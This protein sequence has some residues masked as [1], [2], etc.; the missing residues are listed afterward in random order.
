MRKAL[1]GI[2][3]VFLS[4][5]VVAQTI[6]E[7]EYF[8][9]TD[10]G[11]G[12]G[13][14]VAITP[15][16]TI[17]EMFNVPTGALSI[18]FHDLFV[19]VK[20]D[21]GIITITPIGGT[22]ETEENVTSPSGTG[23]IQAAFPN[24]LE[25]K[26][27][28][29]NF[30]ATETVTG[31][32]SGATATIDSF[33]ANWS[34]PE[35][36]LIYID[37]T[38]AGIVQVDALE[39]FI[40][41]DPG[42]GMGTP[43]PAFSATA[44][45]NE[46]AN[47]PTGAL[48]LGFHT[49][50]V[51][52]RAVGGTWGLPE[53]RLVFVDPTAGGGVIL[54]DELEYFIDS[55]PGYG[56][57]TSF[58]AF[59]A[60]NVVNQM[61]NI[62]T[63]ALSV[64]FHTIFV[65][66]KSVEGTWGIPE[67]RI[68]YVD[69]SGGMVNVEEIEYFFDT[70]PGYGMGTQFTAFT[71]ANI[72]N[73]VENIAT[74]SLSFGFH[75]L[76]IR[77][78]SV[79]GTWGLP[80]SRI[81]YVD[82]SGTV[83]SD[84]AAL[85]YFLDTDPGYGMATSI[86]IGTPGFNVMEMFKIL[87]NDLPQG[88]HV[89][90]IRAQNNDGT[91]GMLETRTIT[92]EPT[93][94]LDFDGTD[95]YVVLPTSI[96]LNSSPA[97]TVEAWIILED[98][99]GE[100]VIYSE[101][102]SAGTMYVFK[103]NSGFVQMLVDN[104]TMFSAATSASQLE[105][106]RWY[107]VV[108]TY[109][110]GVGTKVYVQGIL[111]GQDA[112]QGRRADGI[113]T[114]TIGRQLPGPLYFDGAI[115]EI[116]LWDKEKTL[117]EIRNDM[118]IDLTG[119][120]ANLRGYYNFDQGFAGMNNSGLTT[121]IDATTNAFDGT[122]NNF[123]L[124]TD[125]S[126]WVKSQVPRPL[127]FNATAITTTGFEANW[128]PMLGATDVRIDVDDN[129]DF[130]SLILS[131]VSIATGGNDMI[132]VAL[133]PGTQYYYRIRGD[134]AGTITNN[135]EIISFMVKPGNS[136]H[137][138]G[139]DD[140]VN[141]GN[142]ASLYN[143]QNLTLEAW[144]KP[145]FTNV[146]DQ[147]TVIST[148]AASGVGGGY[149]MTLG[150]TGLV[151]IFYRDA[152]I[153]DRI[154]VSNTALQPGEWVHIAGVIENAGANSNLRLYINGNLDASSSAVPGVPDY[155]NV[156]PL[157][158]G[159]NGD[160]AAESNPGDREFGGEMDAV[161]IWNTARSQ[162]D[163]QDNL[164]SS[165]EG[166]EPGL[167][168]NYR[169]DQGN[170]NASN[171]G[172]D[173]LPD[174]AG[175]NDGTL[176]NFDLGAGDLNLSN[177]VVSGAQTPLANLV[178]TI[179]VAN[180]TGV[181][182]ADNIVFNFDSNLVQ[183]GIDKGTVGDVTDDAIKV[184]GSLSGLI[185]GTYSG[186]GTSTITFDP[187]QDLLPGE[188][189][190]VTVTAGNG[191]ASKHSFSFATSSVG[192]P[193]TPNFFRDDVS[194]PVTASTLDDPRSPVV[195]DL[196][197][198][199]DLDIVANSSGSGAQL[200]WYE[201]DGN[202][203][204]VENTLKGGVSFGVAASTGDVNSDGLVDVMYS[205]EVSNLFSW[206]ENQGGGSFIERPI[207]AAASSNARLILSA[208]IDADG[209]TDLLTGSRVSP[210][211]FWR[212]ND[213]S[214]SFAD[215]NITTSWADIVGMEI[216]DLDD[217][218]DLDIA[219]AFFAQNQVAWY[220]NDGVQNFTEISIAMPTA[221]N[222]IT[223]GDVNGDTHLDLV[224]LTNLGEVIWY[225]NGGDQ[226]F[227]PFVVHDFNPS[228]A[229]SSF[230]AD[231]DG[232]GDTDIV[233]GSDSELVWLDNDGSQNFTL[234]G[235]AMNG[236]YQTTPVA[237]MDADGDLDI[238][239]ATSGASDGVFVHL[240]AAP[241]PLAPSDL[242]PIE[243]NDSQIDLVW[244]DNSTNETGFIIERS[245]NDNLSFMP[246]GTVGANQTTYSDTGVSPGNR[247]YYRVFAD[248]T[249]VKSDPT[250]EKFASTL[251]QPGNAIVL[252]GSDDQI[253]VGNPSELQI[254]GNITV[255]GWFRITG[256]LNNFSTLAGKWHTGGS[257]AAYTILWGSGS[258]GFG[259]T[260][261]GG[262]NQ[263]AN[264][265]N[266]YDDGLW[267]HV[268]GTWDGTNQTIYV[269]GFEINS[270]PAA[271]PALANPSIDF[272]IGADAS[273][274]ADR[275]FPGEID[276]IRVWSEARTEAQIRANM[277]SSLT[278]AEPNL[279]A[280]Y[281][282]DQTGGANTN[283]PDRTFNNN[284]GTFSGDPTTP[285]IGSGAFTPQIPMPAS[286]LITTEISG[287]QI[288]LSWTVNSFTETGFNIEVSPGDNISFT[289]LTTVG[290]GVSSFSHTGLTPGNG[291]Y[292]RVIATNSSGDAAPSNE[293]FGSTITPPGN[294]L[295]FDGID[296]FITIPDYPGFGGLPSQD[297][298]WSLWVKVPTDISGG[299]GNSEFILSKSAVSPGLARVTIGVNKTTG[300]AHGVVQLDAGTSQNLTGVT[301]LRDD[302][303]HHISFVRD[304]NA[305]EIRFYV[306]GQ[307][308]T[309]IQTDNDVDG[310][311]PGDFIIGDWG[312]LP[313][314]GRTFSGEVDEVRIWSI[315]RS[316]ADIQSTQFTTLQGNEPGLVA[317]YRFDQ[318][319]PAGNNPN[320][321]ILPDRS[322]NVNDGILS[323]F[324][325]G[326]G[327]PNLSNWIMSGAPLKA[328]GLVIDADITA[329]NDFFNDLGGAN[330][331]DNTGWLVGDPS[332]WFGI[333]TADN[334]ITGINLPSNNLIGDVPI[335]FNTLTGLQTF[336]L[337]DNEVTSIPDISS[338]VDLSSGDITDNF[339]GF[340][341]LENGNYLIAALAYQTQKIFFT[342]EDVL[343]D[344]NSLVVIDREEPTGASNIYS[345]FKDSNPITTEFD[346]T[347][348]FNSVQ[349]TDEGTYTAVIT[350]GVV[351]D[352][353]IST[354]NFTLKVSSL[355]RDRTALTNI[356]NAT[357]GIDWTDNTNWLDPDV[358]TWFGVTVANNRVTRLELPDNN[359]QND[360]PTDLR[361]IGQIEVISLEDNELRA[362][363]DLSDNSRQPQ[364][365]T[366][367]VVNNRLGFGDIEPN[368]PISNLSFDPQRRFGVTTTELV[369]VN[370]D[371]AVSIDISGDNNQ[372]QWFRKPRRTPEDVA[373]TPVDGATNATYIIEDI[374]FD[375]MGIYYVEVTSSL[376]D[377]K[378]DGFT[379][380][381]RNQNVFAV[382]DVSG[383]VFLNETAGITLDD[384]D[385]LIY[386]VLAPGQPF[387]L[388][389]TA[390]LTVGGAYTF[391]DI[392]LGDY[393]LLSRSG[394]SFG[395]EVL[396]TYYRS[397]NDWVLAD[398]LLLRDVVQNINID[399]LAVPDP[400]NPAEG[401]ALIGGF[402]ESDFP[403][404]TDPEAGLREDARRRVRRA[405]C[406]L[407]RS[408]AKNRVL[409]DTLVLVAYTETDDDGNFA[410]ENVPP[411]NYFLNI[412]IPGVPMDSTNLI[413][414]I[415]DENKTNQSFNLE[416]LALPD[417]IRLTLIEETGILR[418]Y[419]TNLSVYPNPAE[420]YIFINYEKLNSE[421]IEVYL[422]DIKGELIQSIGLQKGGSNQL[423]IDL[424]KLSNGIYLLVFN[425]RNEP[426]ETIGSYRIV[427]NR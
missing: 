191:I 159:S 256:T 229:N 144:V 292:Y 52:A 171:T 370:D 307:L 391:D 190:S 109:Q 209:D 302:Q 148:I 290:P 146:T 303:W 295:E 170:A 1:T 20:E 340:G 42:Y 22:Y 104:G 89:L 245:L 150:N 416:A 192:G 197:S 36:R 78:K 163:L 164:F 347:L 424:T 126:N 95:D 111:A 401:D 211:L 41:T 277:F 16:S 28:S 361:D 318:G 242:L 404:P 77:A 103:V 90:G 352:L 145:D 306:D 216:A 86:P 304:R 378:L 205:D 55:D 139:I 72:I 301:D 334:R 417:A 138:D 97:S 56:M 32:T 38:G 269:D 251:T 85:E 200:A 280:Y 142:D 398:R 230:I 179:P 420:D 57:G 275:F 73:Q 247:Y 316:Q 10:P 84:I 385:I 408:R 122:L 384:G 66:A 43:F 338:L 371:F 376:N 220:E 165:F 271:F 117:A 120:E 119:S 405:G 222:S 381:N 100:H 411:G 369:Q 45:V 223:I 69:P 415:I 12:M 390:Q 339:I 400:F 300:F 226:S 296:D 322:P 11:Y 337:S 239:T 29:G 238:V 399:M 380:R 102:R 254:T 153:T 276:E 92:V 68:V 413:E 67:S 363:P 50:F 49:V 315:P 351:L 336:D 18:G 154:I 393:I 414:F 248:N 133:T 184:H 244:T 335:N 116:R 88:Q 257:N 261:S 283:L 108:G 368:L 75:T 113:A 134:I 421:G 208:D 155:T 349:F 314:D 289:P 54:V 233:A 53:P 240:N 253:N 246:V 249:G 323:N 364:L 423:E 392:I 355:E 204:F 264:T 345:W 115:D 325:L 224:V 76:F 365:T 293:E 162:T 143:H 91:W 202:L 286:D 321:I 195:A 427:V 158:L 59:T 23:I 212:E 112:Q 252:D 5:Q 110:D 348:T 327:D 258:L 305:D 406:S 374:D 46:M 386:E 343:A 308:D 101:E 27:T 169:F 294:A 175:F 259:L 17:N 93:N 81:V 40:D 83:N 285:W 319:S 311:N 3:L 129:A 395:D 206:F 61:A 407:L 188:K 297:F 425:D 214:E 350:N 64:G 359:L 79:G 389:G 30:V 161:R 255:E 177:W 181:A 19:R 15:G 136:L 125:A 356:F 324:D 137:F 313:L 360:M 422:T 232:D 309:P 47:I 8:I 176:V 375:N 207:T 58:T 354:A 44:I 357:G 310:S 279:N 168:A 225:D 124:D 132:S 166:V 147:A 105:T 284:N 396:Q 2:L 235:I 265:F 13:T 118:F 9:D 25:V 65:R 203:A 213:G 160:G 182:V 70:D 394:A 218:G 274:Q 328:S 215:Q 26:I 281:R 263:T 149:Q 298:T 234:Q 194:S 157:Y 221:P 127:V 210:G 186:D 260:S 156:A 180:A 282:F 6:T 99:T 24:R 332:G 397:I 312:R 291:Y 219:A 7:M 272:I 320:N 426:R 288:D 418:R 388:A 82:P 278:G 379:I 34:V 373:G 151:N 333:T 201:N 419:F 51:R 187:A 341:S 21:G 273:A 178:A 94:A 409:Q 228:A 231:I 107:H 141:A 196:D 267:H 250:T 4:S 128:D 35:S 199:G 353:V 367:N 366:L 37:P 330:W 185:S 63:G 403:D 326:A 331:L 60:A 412:Q 123:L 62:P 237:D 241:M 14:T 74:G 189:I 183:A 193:L 198:D 236:N 243:I 287:T 317:Y 299:N 268:A 33:F 39:Y 383:G 96:A 173:I 174:I 358:S 227:T 71:A 377:P 382:T 121:L 266:S 372:Y 98:L 152:T 342:D 131:D 410:F 270:I 402:L 172:I 217:D 362:L 130:T 387:E 329:L 106:G 31:G 262:T 80:E 114:I 167:L 135:S 140:F 48:S 87:A 346:P 344:V